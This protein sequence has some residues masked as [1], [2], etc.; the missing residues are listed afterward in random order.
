MAKIANNMPPNTIL[1]DPWLKVRKK[2]YIFYNKI[3]FNYSFVFL[4]NFFQLKNKLKMTKSNHKQFNL[5][6]WM[7]KSHKYFYISIKKIEPLPLPVLKKS[8]F[9]HLNFF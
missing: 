7:M 1:Y 2:G 3:L 9:L 4:I 8:L 5:L 6:A